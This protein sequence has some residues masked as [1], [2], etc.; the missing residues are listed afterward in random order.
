MLTHGRGIITADYGPEWKILHKFG[1]KT[2]RR[3]L[4]ARCGLKLFE[5]NFN[6]EFP[7]SDLDW[8][9]KEARLLQISAQFI[10]ISDTSK[11]RKNFDLRD[12]STV[13]KN[14]SNHMIPFSTGPRH[15]LGEQLAKM[16]LFIFI[17]VMFQKLEVLPNP[18]NPLPPFHVGVDSLVT[19][20][21]PDFDVVFEL[22]E[23]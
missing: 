10:T 12:F 5:R 7:L 14:S 16:K 3:H 1:F 9:V 15:C 8:V 17:T 21:A 19:Y 11:I 18:H 22:R 23:R 13:T 6:S 4:V 2:L 20:E